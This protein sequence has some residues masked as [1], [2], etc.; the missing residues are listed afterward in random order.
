MRVAEPGELDR[1][2]ALARVVR[3][4]AEYLAQTDGRLFGQVFDA[5]RARTLPLTPEL[6]ERVD[7]FVARFGRLQDTLADKLLPA[8]L[9]RKRG[10]NTLLTRVSS[11]TSTTGRSSANP[12]RQVVPSP[13]SML[14]VRWLMRTTVPT[15]V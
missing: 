3:R 5:E 14:A 4:E 6:A 11:Q 8:L 13:G 1:L 7:A 2:W 9:R 15:T 12:T 10:L